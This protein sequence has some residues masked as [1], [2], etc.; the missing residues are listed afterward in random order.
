MAATNSDDSAG[1]FVKVF[2][3]GANEDDISDI[4]NAIDYPS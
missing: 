2:I 4:E 3:S 1:V